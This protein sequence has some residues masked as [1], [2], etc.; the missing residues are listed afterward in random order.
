[1]DLWANK[2][3]LLKQDVTRMNELISRAQ[4]YIQSEEAMKSLVNQSLKYNN[5]RK[6]INSQRQTTTYAN[7]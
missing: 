6:K 2:K 5:D 4:P 3:Y 1:M 7:N